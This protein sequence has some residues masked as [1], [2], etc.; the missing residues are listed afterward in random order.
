MSAASKSA[1]SIIEKHKKLLEIKEKP[2]AKQTKSDNTDTESISSSSSKKTRE[3]SAYNVF[4][5]TELPLIKAE[6]IANGNNSLT[7]K[8]LMGILSERWTAHKKKL[9]DGK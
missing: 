2:K 4:M 9:G 8:E 5:K 7:R 6:T 1:K 3:P